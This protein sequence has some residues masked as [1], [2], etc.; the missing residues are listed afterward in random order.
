LPNVDPLENTLTTENS[1]Q[2]GR[3]YLKLEGFFIAVSLPLAPPLYLIGDEVVFCIARLRGE[4]S[5]AGALEEY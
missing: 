5:A 1:A 2:P 3:K 4:Q